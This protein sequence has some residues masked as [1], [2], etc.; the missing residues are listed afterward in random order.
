M[1]NNVKQILGCLRQKEKK[2]AAIPFRKR[3][4]MVKFP[5]FFFMKRKIMKTGDE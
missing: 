3:E 2:N 4:G 1:D 5:A